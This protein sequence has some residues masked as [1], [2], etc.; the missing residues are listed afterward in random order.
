MKNLIGISGKM[1]SGKDTVGAI[2]QCLTGTGYSDKENIDSL[3]KIG[4]MPLDLTQSPFI[5]K[6]FAGK[7]KDIICLLLGCTRNDLESAGF[8]NKELG[9]DWIQ[10]TKT[11][12]D[13]ITRYTD[14]ISK[15]AYDTLSKIKFEYIT[16]KKIRLTPRLIL[17]LL[18][19]D[20]GRDI[21][22]PNIW[23][24]A[25]FADYKQQMGYAEGSYSCTCGKCN[26]EFTGD[27]R[28]VRCKD[29]DI[30]YPSWIITDLRFPNELEAIKARDGLTIRVNTNRAGEL[31]SHESETAL[32]NA[33]FDYTIDNSGTFEELIEEVKRILVAE[34][35]IN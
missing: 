20:C 10:Y 32:D 28:A 17:Q 31:S 35:I 16:H 29:C 19:T 27:K 5:I 14:L 2:I 3:K 34:Q 12:N 21:I 23:V 22:H 33:E 26:K 1:G 11:Y 6:K 9:E 7:L 24:N 25:L 18:G 4:F 15:D 8:K 13:G 30:F